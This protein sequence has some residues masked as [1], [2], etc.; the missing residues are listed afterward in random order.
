MTIL[1]SNLS[2][3]EEVTDLIMIWVSHL[4]KKVLWNDGSHLSHQ[5]ESII[6]FQIDFL[7]VLTV[8][9]C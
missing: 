2:Q 4:Y 7:S 6:D 1:I 9:C 5:D 3:E 8:G